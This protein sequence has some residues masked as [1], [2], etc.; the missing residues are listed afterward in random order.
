MNNSIRSLFVVA[1]IIITTCSLATCGFQE[2]VNAEE[3]YAAASNLVAEMEE[4]TKK[5]EPKMTTEFLLSDEKSSTE[6]VSPDELLIGAEDSV[7]ETD[8]YES[9]S[10]Y[11][12]EYSTV[13]IV[14]ISKQHAYCFV[15]GVCKG[16]TDCVTGNLSTSP[17]PVGT[18]SVWYK[19]SDFNMLDDPRYY[20]H[21][22]TFFNGG[23]AIH[24][25]DAWRSEYGGEIYKTNGSHGCV[26]TPLSF[27]ELAYLNT[28]IGTRVVILP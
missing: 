10:S 6:T 4:D 20:T 13:M 25:A 1:V 15:D 28:D 5:V 7:E 23:I 21:Y 27:S 24:D 12:N 19:R 14:E 9:F 8:D 2:S 16:E 22:A 26:N 17:T 11:I 3:E 18:Y